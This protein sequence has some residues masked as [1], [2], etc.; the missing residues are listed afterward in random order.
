[1]ICKNTKGQNTNKH[2]CSSLKRA[3]FSNATAKL[4]LL[5]I[6][7]QGSIHVPQEQTSLYNQLPC[8]LQS[9][10]TVFTF[11]ITEADIPV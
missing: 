2:T 1:M 8:G 6:T 3:R 9:M 4:L 11:T 7:V 5:W 10:K